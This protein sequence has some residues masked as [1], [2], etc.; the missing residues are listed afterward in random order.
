[1]LFSGGHTKP[2]DKN[3]GLLVVLQLICFFVPFSSVV[4][5]VRGQAF[6]RR[7]WRR[8]PSV[9]TETRDNAWSEESA[10]WVVGDDRSNDD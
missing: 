4:P 6:V 8:C 10:C 2:Y 3:F 5:G 1:M 9:K 7:K